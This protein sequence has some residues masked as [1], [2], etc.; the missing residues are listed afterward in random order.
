M[1]EHKRKN[2]RNKP[3]EICIK[4]SDAILFYVTK[5]DKKL[6]LLNE[7]QFW[8]LII[9]NYCYKSI[10]YLASTIADDRWRRKNVGKVM[11]EPRNFQCK[12]V[13]CTNSNESQ[14]QKSSCPQAIMNESSCN[15]N[16]PVNSESSCRKEMLR[17]W[18]R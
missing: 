13:N 17:K 3:A 7:N 11:A 4:K 10:G 8:N 5:I 14:R 12:S 16:R 9:S 2:Q 6:Y 1:S 15:G 18:S